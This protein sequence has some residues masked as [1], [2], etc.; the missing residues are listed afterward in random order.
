MTVSLD[1]NYR[2]KLWRY[3][4]PRPKL[5]R[6]LAGLADVLRRE[7]GGLPEGAW[8]RGGGRP[9]AGRLDVGAYERLTAEVMSAFPISNGSPSRCARA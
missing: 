7:R 1:L 5:M 3:G 6:D 8:P 9:H 2:S 4:R